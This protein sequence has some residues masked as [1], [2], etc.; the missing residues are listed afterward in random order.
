MIIGIV[1]IIKV[2]YNN[3]K[4]NSE[5]EEHFQKSKMGIYGGNY[6]RY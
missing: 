1:I 2:R 4:R 5:F 3:Y 6:A